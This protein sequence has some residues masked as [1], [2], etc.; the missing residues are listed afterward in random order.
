VFTDLYRKPVALRSPT[1]LADGTYWSRGR[2]VCLVTPLPRAAA[3][4][5]LEPQEP[6]LPMLLVAVLWLGQIR[7]IVSQ[8]LEASVQIC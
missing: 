7:A 5:L 3:A 2:Y 8:L 4:F 6:S 1:C